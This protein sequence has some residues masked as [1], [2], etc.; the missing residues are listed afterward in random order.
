MVRG[1]EIARN[2][3]HPEFGGEKLESGREIFDFGHVGYNHRREP[4]SPTAMDKG[5]HGNRACS[6]NHPPNGQ[7]RVTMTECLDQGGEVGKRVPVGHTIFSR[8]PILLFLVS[9]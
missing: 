1:A 7:W 2:P 3:P 5:S 8:W 6:G 4:G 9:R